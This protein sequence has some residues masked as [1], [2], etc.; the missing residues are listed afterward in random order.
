MSR[1]I[2]VSRRDFLTTSGGLVLGFLLGRGV[3]EAQDV[4]TPLLSGGLGPPPSHNPNGHIRIGTEE[5]VTFLIPR[6]EMGQAPTT[7][8][9]RTPAQTLRGDASQLRM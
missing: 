8:S 7:G 1:S 3:A 6:S 2:N 9:S 4:P 5:S